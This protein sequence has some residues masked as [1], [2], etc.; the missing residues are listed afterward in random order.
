MALRT[1]KSRGFL[2]G[3]DFALVDSD[4]C[5]SSRIR[6]ESSRDS[7]DHAITMQD[8]EMSPLIPEQTDNDAVPHHVASLALSRCSDY[9]PVHQFQHEL[10]SFIWSV[11]FILS[12]FRCGRRVVN[13]DLEKWYVGDWKTVENA[14]R[15]FLR[16]VRDGGTFAGEFAE[17]LG[18]DQQPL[19]AF[20][21]SLANMLAHPEQLR[22]API[23]SALQEAR[24]AYAKGSAS[25]VPTDFRLAAH[26][27]SFVHI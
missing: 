5:N 24:D 8:C 22:A 23:F 15:G 1:E 10:E 12:G 13:T 11:F 9:P 3:F 19:V 26:V 4:V 27:A 18:V 20:S 21:R 14:K 25:T 17:S 16:Q 6:L 7:E 2:V